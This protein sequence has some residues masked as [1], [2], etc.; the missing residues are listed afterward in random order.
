MEGEGTGRFSRSHAAC[1]QGFTDVITN[2]LKCMFPS[3]MLCCKHIA[4]QSK[5]AV[6]SHRGGHH[7]C[8]L[9]YVLEYL[10]HVTRVRLSA[11]HTEHSIRTSLAVLPAAQQ[12]SGPDVLEYK[13]VAA[14][15][16]SFVLRKQRITFS[17][18]C[19]S[20]RMCMPSHGAGHSVHRLVSDKDHAS[21]LD[22]RAMQTDICRFSELYEC[23]KEG[24][25]CFLCPD[26]V[27]IH[28]QPN[29]HSPLLASLLLNIVIQRPEVASS[30]VL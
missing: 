20:S 2:D 13:V 14:H 26:I 15:A 16:H 25:H 8:C 28:V 21:S 18:I 10:A 30:P 22:A 7:S 5:S 17:S 27:R 24:P 11:T 6:N 4:L 19:L 9:R 1:W 23:I 12:T 29:A 3:S